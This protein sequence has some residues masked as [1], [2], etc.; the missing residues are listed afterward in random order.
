MRS[1]GCA[2]WVMSHSTSEQSVTARADT[3]YGGAGPDGIGVTTGLGVFPSTGSDVI[4]GGARGDFIFDGGGADTIHGGPGTDDV[5]LADDGIHDIVVCGPGHDQVWGATPARQ[6]LPA[7][8]RSTS[9]SPDAALT[10]QVGQSCWASRLSRPTLVASA[11]ISDRAR[12]RRWCGWCPR[13]P[14]S[15][16]TT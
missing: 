3:I 13:A 12:T 15:K 11:A 14:G 9:G 6:L 2:A 8:K 5:L 4:F 7:V 16:L 1:P 10:P